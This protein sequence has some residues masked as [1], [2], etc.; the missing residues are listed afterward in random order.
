MRE[1]RDTFLQIVEMVLVGHGIRYD[2]MENTID[3]ANE[4]L[5]AIVTTSGTAEQAV[6]IIMNETL[7]GYGV[8][9]TLTPYNAGFIV[10][11]ARQTLALDS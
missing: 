5:D 3:L 8:D 6:T 7:E 1:P 9:K 10:G 11:A 2:R 4:I